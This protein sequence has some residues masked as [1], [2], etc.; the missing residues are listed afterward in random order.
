MSFL[1]DTSQNRSPLA[2]LSENTRAII[3]DRIEGGESY[4]K[5]ATAV[6]C[7]ASTVYATVQRWRRDRSLTSTP[8]PGRP[9]VISDREQHALYRSARKNPKY[10]YHEL[11]EN[12]LLPSPTPL[13]QHPPLRS[14]IMRTLKNFGLRHY[15][16]AER[17][18]LELIHVILRRKW[19]QRYRYFAWR[20]RVVKYSDECLVQRGSGAQ[21][22]WVFRYP[23]EKYRPELIT[24]KEKG[25]KISQMVWGAIWLDRRGR[26]RRSPLVIMD[27]DFRSKK[28]GY[29]G[30]SYIKTLQ[31]GL[32]PYYK[33]RQAFVQDNAPIY[34]C[35]ETRE[36]L[37]S[38]G[39]WTLDWPPYLLDLNPIEHL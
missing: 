15:K 26:P 17:P 20:R 25:G 3:I 22:E 8:R 7:S 36:F 23:H 29:S 13:R 21:A 30:A 38:Y 5:V 10:N 39:I 12:A 33:P 11:A 31:E 34:K 35:K 24:E 1:S 9:K 4:R 6:G 16:A 32:L 2:E 19:Q 27:R 18:K 37:E 14:T 28:N